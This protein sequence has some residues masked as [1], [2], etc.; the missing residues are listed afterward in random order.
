MAVGVN[1]GLE[2]TKTDYF[3]IFFQ[4][5][6]L[7]INILP[8]AYPDEIAFSYFMRYHTLSGNK[9]WKHTSDE[10]F[11]DSNRIPNLY[12]PTN[13]NYFCSQVPQNLDLTSDNIIDKM[14]IFPFYKAFMPE[15]RAII[16]IEKMKSNDSKGLINKM[17]FNS[18]NTFVH[19]EKIV[20][21]CPKCLHE[22][23]NK[24]GEPYIHR[25]HQIP[26]NSICYKHKIPLAE[27]IIVSNVNNYIVFNIDSI[28]TESIN[29]K[30]I[31]KNL[32]EYYIDLAE[33]IN[34]LLDGV[35][36]DYDLDKVREKY[37]KKLQEKGYYISGGVKRNNLANDMNSYYKKDF[38]LNLESDIYE[39]VAWLKQMLTNSSAVVH[40]IRHL[41]LIRFLFGGVKE[42]A[43]YN[44]EY[45]SFGDGPYPCLNPVAN[46]FKKLVI[47]HCEV[48]RSNLNTIGVFR[49]SCGFIYSR[50][51]P[52]NSNDDRFKY[53][54]VLQ[55]GE[56]WE[57][58]LKETIIS[59]NG[60][61]SN[62]AKEMK[63]SDMAVVRYAN[64]LGIVDKLNTKI[65]MQTSPRSYKSL[66]D[67]EYEDYKKTILQYISEN[68]D[69]TR[70]QIRKA[71][72]KQIALVYNREKE[73]LYNVLPK[74]IEISQVSYYKNIDWK[75][76]DIELERFV[77]NTIDELLKED[78]PKRITRS[79]VAKRINY[80]GLQKPNVIKKL[81][82]T[83]KL[84][85]EY[86]ETV[87][88]F[89][90]RKTKLIQEVKI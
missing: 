52:D 76:K 41:L 31:D 87:D 25:S 80:F 36:Q 28:N 82:R 27:H 19:R 48:K 68:K 10:L 22:D 83:E 59:S 47:S 43:D 42:F 30:D 71:L 40:P 33:D 16:I 90:E 29:V 13:L 64:K 49:C 67:E 32:M 73:W 46:H 61:I 74:A 38:L 39:D 55:F 51:I 9:S 5:C 12:Y 75:Q 45:N 11:G 66:S 3:K 53:K 72:P 85:L 14:T 54:K 86:C 60:N 21:I 69:A 6:V 23:K 4:G 2:Y 81:P 15:K 26:G 65:R 37:W 35:L 88:E 79:L 20:K 89:E 18:R 50:D 63:C 34:C 77:R 1:T 17:G 24:Y 78:N 56:V 7:M 8:E 58:K 84:L 62:V 70:N 57:D 44:V